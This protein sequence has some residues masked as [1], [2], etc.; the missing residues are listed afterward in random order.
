MI[1]KISYCSCGLF[2][3]MFLVRIAGSNYKMQIRF[4]KCEPLCWM[5]SRGERQRR[6]GPAVFSKQGITWLNQVSLGHWRSL[7]LVGS[8]TRVE[9]CTCWR[10]VRVFHLLSTTRG[11][12]DYLCQYAPCN[13]LVT[14]RTDSIFGGRA[15]FRLDPMLIREYQRMLFLWCLP[16]A[17]C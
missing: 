1:K 6:A 13:T 2:N 16:Q 11:C 12:T 7:G 4:S 9:V 3:A 8:W 15:W 14:Q 5:V 10:C 17:S